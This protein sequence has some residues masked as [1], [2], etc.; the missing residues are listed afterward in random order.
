MPAYHGKSLVT[1]RDGRVRHDGTLIGQVQR[2]PGSGDWR[3]EH[4]T[5]VSLSDLHPGRPGD[6]A[7]QTALT[8]RAAAE[9]LAD[10]DQR[11]AHAAEQRADA[12]Q[13]LTPAR[14]AIAR[15][16]QRAD[17]A[18]RGPLYAITSTDRHGTLTT[19]YALTEDAA[20][21]AC[22]ELAR[23]GH[24][25]ITSHPPRPHHDPVR[26]LSELGA[27]RTDQRAAAAFTTFKIRALTLRLLAERE[28][29]QTAAA[30]AGQVDRMT[31]RTWTGQRG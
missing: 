23:A 13:P 10:L 11:I 21:G 5:G 2:D 29:D 7:A 19:R 18:E 20:R 8:K 31:I 9:L 28:I 4:A 14:V 25:D 1:G 12:P 3:Y 26:W 24:T 6:R 27:Q 22:A 15:A 30:A 16:E 17:A